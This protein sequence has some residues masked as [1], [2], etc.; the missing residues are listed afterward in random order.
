MTGE[1]PFNFFMTLF[2]P[3]DNLMIMDYN[4]VLKTLNGYTPQEFIECLEESFD[5]EP[6][7]DGMTSTVER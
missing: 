7:E 4:R 6:L 2:Y 1:E 5:I 3:A